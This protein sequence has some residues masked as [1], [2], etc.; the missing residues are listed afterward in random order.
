MR[1]LPDLRQLLLW[2][3]AVASLTTISSAT[4]TPPKPGIRWHASKGD[5]QPAYVEVLN[6]PPATL[7]NLT[8]G[9]WSLPQWQRLFPVGVDS[10]PSTPG[11]EMSPMTGEYR[12]VGA[13]LRFTPPFPLDAGLRYRASFRPGVLPDAAA[14]SQPQLSDTFQVNAP[15]TTPTTVVSE[16]HPGATLLPENLLK[17]YIH[18]SAP[19]RRGHIYDYIRLQDDHGKSVELPFLEID[20]ELWDPE[21]K[22]LTLFLDPGRIKRGVRPLEEVGPSLI[23]GRSYTLVIDR[24]WQDAAG[25]SLRSDFKNRFHIGPPDRVSPAPAT[26]KISAPRRNTRHPLVVQFNE[27]LDSAILRRVLRVLDDRGN[28]VAG[29]VALGA[30]DRRWSLTPSNPWLRGTYLLLVPTAIEDLA[31]NNVD[32]PF[33]VDLTED[34]LPQLIRTS[35]KLPFEIR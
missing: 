5:P 30:E 33:D 22:R 27:P 21:M 2:A 7:Q 35:V 28:P 26:W 23:A 3:S 8:R 14:D 34:G 16:V 4:A 13:T 31:G 25:N 24:H 9:D 29:T 11:G 6:L 32:K 20:E 19:M 10:S 18:F 1:G 12:V 15:A 17:F